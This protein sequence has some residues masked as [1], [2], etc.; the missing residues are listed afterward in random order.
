MNLWKEMGDEDKEKFEFYRDNVDW[1]SYAHNSVFGGRQYLLK[2]S[3]DTIPKGRRK[4]KFLFFA[5]YT[6]IAVFWFLV[7]KLVSLFF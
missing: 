4:I 1:D 3:E 7:Y 2:E 5:H 6:V